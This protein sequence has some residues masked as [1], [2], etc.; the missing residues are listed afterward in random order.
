MLI[1]IKN[2]LT[3]AVIFSSDVENNT[4]KLT[5]QMAFE[6]KINLRGAYLRGAYLSGVTYGIASISKNILQL[7]G[8]QWAVFIFDYH[9]KIGCKLYLTVEWE[10]FSDDEISKMDTKALEFWTENK[11]IILVCAKNHQKYN[12]LIG[13]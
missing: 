7:L 9:I 12:K 10:A 8:K 5:V 3:G 2:R 1:E 13:G 6:S 11:E 4:V